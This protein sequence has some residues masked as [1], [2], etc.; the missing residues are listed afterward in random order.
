MGSQ[1]WQRLRASR[2]YARMTQQQ[3]ADRLG[4]SKQSVSSWE[5]WEDEKRAVPRWENLM[6]IASATGAPQKWLMSDESDLESFWAELGEPEGTSDGGMW[7]AYVVVSQLPDP[8]GGTPVDA[9]AGL[10]AYRRTWID[11]KGYQ[12]GKIFSYVVGTNAFAHACVNRGDTVLVDT[13]DTSIR[14]GW[15]IIGPVHTFVHVKSQ[16][17]GKLTIDTG[18]GAQDLPA[19][20]DVIGRAVSQSREL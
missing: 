16:L 4:V 2:R 5:A 9:G 7:S 10:L 13:S 14:P 3:L 20:L 1:L 17:T 12:P 19:S 11:Y 8:D 18:D 15:W 6:G